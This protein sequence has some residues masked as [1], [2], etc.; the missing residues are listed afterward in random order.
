MDRLQN[1]GLVIMEVSQ[2][3]PKSIVQAIRKG[4]L[5]T[6]IAEAARISSSGNIFALHVRISFSGKPCFFLKN[7]HLIESNQ[8][9]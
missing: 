9:H 7:F 3:S 8:T 5:E 4:R 2:T 1:S 6:I